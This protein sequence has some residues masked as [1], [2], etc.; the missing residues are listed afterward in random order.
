LLEHAG[1]G[2]TVADGHEKL[3]EHVDWVTKA[4]GGRGA[5]RE[6]VDDMVSARD[7]WDEVLADYRNGQR[8]STAAQPESEAP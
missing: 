8:V 6:V 2:I 7:L 1:L 3:L 4:A 5:V